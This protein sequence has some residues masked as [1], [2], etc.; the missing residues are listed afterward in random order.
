[1]EEK[2]RQSS[3]NKQ[4]VPPSCFGQAKL[5]LRLLQPPSP[6]EAP[7][8]PASAIR[9]YLTHP[10][11][12][13]QK[14]SVHPREA[15]QRVALTP[16]T[17]FTVFISFCSPYMERF[18]SNTT[19]VAQE[20][21][22]SSSHHAGQSVVATANAMNYSTLCWL[23]CRSDLP[24]VQSRTTFGHTDPQWFHIRGATGI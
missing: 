1:M 21:P 8:A 5:H 10:F 3:P 11:D 2:T 7:L 18:P 22:T 6:W 19:H 4:E 9:S 17:T 16:P 20:S 12:N 23:G 24:A 14:K 13:L 15:S